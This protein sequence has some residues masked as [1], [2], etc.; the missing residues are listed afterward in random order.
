MTRDHFLHSL[1]IEALLANQVR[2]IRQI[3]ILA[4]RHLPA[5]RRI[6]IESG[7]DGEQFSDSIYDLL[8][9]MTTDYFSILLPA[10]Q[11]ST[12]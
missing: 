5:I 3:D 12:Q 10:E 9:D 2:D 7:F 1:I 11:E 4:Q 8:L 6:F